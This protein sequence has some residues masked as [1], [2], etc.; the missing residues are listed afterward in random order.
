M[1]SPEGQDAIKNNFGNKDSLFARYTMI[2]D[3]IIDMRHA[4]GA[5]NETLEWISDGYPSYIAAPATYALGVGLEVDQ[6]TSGRISGAK[7]PSLGQEGS[8]AFSQ[9]DIPSNIFGIGAA[10][11][12]GSL[13][14]ALEAN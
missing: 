9:E 7:Q 1:K 2:G 3:Q 14:D 12:G 4:S 8:S 5:Y 6:A 11:S 13:L 10:I